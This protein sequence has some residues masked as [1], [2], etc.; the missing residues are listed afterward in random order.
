MTINCYSYRN[1]VRGSSNARSGGMMTSTHP[2]MSRGKFCNYVHLNEIVSEI[3]HAV[4]ES[5]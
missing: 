1:S 3:K 4:I 2:P 5:M